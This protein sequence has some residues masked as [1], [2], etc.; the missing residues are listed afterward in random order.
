MGIRWPKRLPYTKR[1]GA[2]VS[3]AQQKREVQD[4]VDGGA[5]PAAL[6][7]LID[8]A[9][10]NIGQAP[11]ENPAAPT[12]ASLLGEIVWLLSM[13]PSHRYFFLSDLEWLVMTPILLKQFRLYRDKQGRPAGLVLWANLTEE[14]E[15]R[16][17]AGAT[18]LRP[19][20]W[21]AGNRLWVIDVV[22]PAVDGNAILQDL[23]DT[24]FK[25][26]QFKYHRTDANGRK[27]AVS[28]DN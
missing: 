10:R 24:V 8:A 5:T 16:L 20:D 12:V 6:Q 3:V 27:H 4:D 14:A 17:E 11:G 25:G 13:T 18:R 2:N 22:A 15:R 19:Q 23:K 21:N 1:V 7:D 9:E 26:Q 28:I